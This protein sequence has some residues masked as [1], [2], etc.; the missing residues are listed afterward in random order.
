MKRRAFL[1]G[2]TV[3]GVAAQIYGAVPIQRASVPANEDLKELPRVSSPGTLRGE[4]LY[5]QLGATGEQ[6]SSI[7]LGG[8]HFAKPTIEESESI[9][10]VHAALDRGINFLDNSWDYNEGQSELRM[11]KALAQEG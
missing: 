6:V 9:R 8:S 10:L 2:L 3:S 7:G 5:R 4:M 11:G 1:T